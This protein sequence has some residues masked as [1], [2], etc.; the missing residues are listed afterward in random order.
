M[1]GTVQ[2]AR[3]GQLGMV[4]ALSKSQT[5]HLGLLVIN[6]LSEPQRQ[7]RHRLRDGFN[8]DRFIVCESVVLFEKK[9]RQSERVSSG[10]LGI[11]DRVRLESR[12]N[13]VISG[14]ELS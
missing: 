3:N 5:R 2:S 1:A 6:A 12:G 14:E 13:P 4:Q 8:L 7:I 11:A 10:G 9:K